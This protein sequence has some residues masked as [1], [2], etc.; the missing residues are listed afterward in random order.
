MMRA[1][2]PAA[3][4]GGTLSAAGEALQRLP[5]I[6]ARPLHL[7]RADQLHAV[8]HAR[9]GLGERLVAH[10]LHARHRGA[11]AEAAVLG[12]DL[13][14]L[15]DFLDVDQE[16]GLDQVGFHLHDDVGA[17]GQDFRRPGRARKQ[18]NGRLQRFRRFVSHIH[19]CH[20]PYEH[21]PQTAAGPFL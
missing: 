17:A 13:A 7:D 15:G 2:A 9:P 1:I 11:D 6:E 19:A 16:R 21:W 5:P 10:D 12:R 18:R 8:E 14:Q 3:I 4:S 20:S